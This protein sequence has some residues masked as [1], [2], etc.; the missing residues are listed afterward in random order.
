MSGAWLGRRGTRQAQGSVLVAVQYHQSAETRG[1]NR[2]HD[3]AQR[4]LFPQA[5]YSPN[6]RQR[7]RSTHA[8]WKNHE[9]TDEHARPGGVRAHYDQRYPAPNPG[10]RAQHNRRPS[11]R[12]RQPGKSRALPNAELFRR[13]R[14]LC[15]NQGKH[16]AS[17][18]RSAILSEH[19]KEKQPE[20]LRSTAWTSLI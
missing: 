9:T 5:S 20:L 11:S 15:G 16:A 12:R 8:T 17:G 7:F 18:W 1:R 10:A 2:G 4:F 14:A 6:P 19:L 3:F 13:R